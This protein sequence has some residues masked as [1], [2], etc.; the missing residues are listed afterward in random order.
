M[1]TWAWKGPLKKSV[2]NFKSEGRDFSNR[3][4]VLIPATGFYEYITRHSPK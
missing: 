2:F 3:D 4:R 1:V